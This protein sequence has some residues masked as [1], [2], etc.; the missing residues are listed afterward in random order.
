MEMDHI[1]YR[2]VQMV[3]ICWVEACDTYNKEYRSYVRFYYGDRSRKQ[4]Q[5]IL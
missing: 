2:S 5:K 4:A 3:L 1:S